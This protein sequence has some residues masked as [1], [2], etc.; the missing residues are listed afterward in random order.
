MTAPALS[1]VV[2]T[3]GRPQEF[4]RLLRSVIASDLADRVELVLVDQSADQS[5]AAV[6]D[7]LAPPASPAPLVRTARTTSGRGASHGRNTGLGLATA[8]VVGFPDDN[9]WYPEGALRAVVE[10]FADDPGLAGLSGR[11]LTEEGRPSMLRWKAAAGPVTRRNFLHTSIM[12]T[13]FFARDHM[14]AVGHFDETMGV[15][16]FGWYGAG[17]ESDLVLRVLAAGGRV[18]YDPALVVLQ[19]EPR[20]APDERFVAK[21]LSYGC[22]MGHLWRLHGLSRA[23]LA[24]YAARKVGGVAVRTAQGR[25]VVARADAAYLRGLAAGLVDRPPRALRERAAVAGTAAPRAGAR[26]GVRGA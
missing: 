18:R 19:E 13:M 4:E 17:E 21:M 15:G 3:V 7:R 23:Q 26:P 16:S 1:L 8:P 5:C 25:P 11:Q 9:C 20:E 6:L 10:A 12:S 24:Y 2:T 14:D 22:G